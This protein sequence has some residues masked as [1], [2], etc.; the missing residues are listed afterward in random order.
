MFS[1]LFAINNEMGSCYSCQTTT[2]FYTI[3][4]MRMLLGFIIVCTKIVLGLIERVKDVNM[5][6]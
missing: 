2:N 3:I 5:N 4:I 1:P 6:F